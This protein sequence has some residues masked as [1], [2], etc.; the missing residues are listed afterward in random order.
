MEISINEINDLLSA[1]QTK[2]IVRIEYYGQQ[3]GKYLQL[4][5]TVMKVDAISQKLQIDNIAID[6]SDIIELSPKRRE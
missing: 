3:E 2:Q 4:T 1:I 5:G 6:F